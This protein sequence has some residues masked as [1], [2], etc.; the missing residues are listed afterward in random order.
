[1]AR[2][3]LSLEWIEGDSSNVGAIAHDE[4][5]DTLCVRFVNGGLYTYEGVKPNV[6][7][8]MLMSESM[9][10]YLSNVIKSTHAYKK[11]ADEQELITHLKA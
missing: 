5:T 4:P 6:F 7:N 2:E 9:G 1:M 10:K 11:W 8:D 3:Q